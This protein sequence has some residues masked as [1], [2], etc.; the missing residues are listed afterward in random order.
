[1]LGRTQVLGLWLVALVACVLVIV[2]A[3]FSA[4]LSAFLP[5]HPTPAQRL[6]IAQLREGPASRLILIALSGADPAQRAEL[7]RTLADRLRQTGEFALVSNGAGAE[8][9]ADARLV[10]AH[11][12][13]LSPAVDAQHFSVPGLRAAI[14]DSIADFS[15]PLG[16]VDSDL[17]ARDPTGE[18]R[19]VLEALSPEV[20]PHTDHGVWGSSDQRRALL[21]AQ[22]RA[23]GS[24]LDAQARAVDS[25]QQ[26]FTRVRP[27][28]GAGAART[29]LELSGPPVFAVQA[30]ATIVREA[31][32]LAAISA[33]LI[34]LLLIAVYRSARMLLLGLLPVIT[35]ALAGVAAVALGFGIVHGVTL[36]FGGTLIGEAMDYSIYLFIQAE[37][38]AVPAG[39]GWIHERWPTV[40]LGMLTSVVGFACLLPSAFPGLSQLG[41]YSVAGLLAAAAVTRF[42]LPRFLSEWQ[43]PALVDSLGRGV[44]RTVRA[45]SGFR[46]WVWL[47][48][49]LA[50]AVLITHRDRLWAHELTVLSPVPESA[51][52][53]DQTLRADLGAPDVRTLIVISGPTRDA[54]LAASERLD[55]KLTPLVKSGVIGGYDSPSRY[56]PSDATQQARMAALPGATTLRER[57]AEALPDLGLK[58]RGLEPFVADVAAARAGSVLGYSD[59]AGTSLAAGVDA[60]TQRDSQGWTALLPLRAGS[61]APINADAVQLAIGDSGPT[62]TS[63]VVLDTKLESDKLY[64]GYLAGAIFWSLAGLIAIVVLLWVALRSARMVTRVVVPLLMAVLMVGAS[65][66]AL[67]RQLTLMHLIGML[68]TVAVASNYALF[69]AREPLSTAFPAAV[70]LQASLVVANLA[71]VIGFGVLALSNVPILSALGTTVALGAV[72]AFV[73][74]AI[75]VPPRGPDAQ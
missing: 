36:G 65:L 34:A 47:L 27:A 23:L 67:G 24:D 13:Q 6:L 71:T 22:T 19:R 74:C 70:R 45:M 48:P 62:G 73:L 51:Q 61:M 30:R 15:S 9:L 32:R 26:A 11:R 68:L 52:R 50:A 54:V 20:Q 53:L 29:S 39:A 33:G 49:A 56:L 21:V 60:L 75:L 17:L 31:S 40:R 12:Y 37:R 25:I 5:A 1:M 66:A 59:L 55:G 44:A 57:L 7:S 10:F 18:S 69:F 41:L 43:V 16:L 3:R 72:I 63:A 42:V 58:L 8:Q 4:D 14:A 2:H 28:E 38:G 46:P 35:G 64:G